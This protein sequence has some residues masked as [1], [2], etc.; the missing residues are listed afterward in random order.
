[1]EGETLKD[2]EEMEG[3]ESGYS[4]SEHILALA[5]QLPIC[6]LGWKKSLKSQ[7]F[8]SPTNP[9]WRLKLNAEDYRLKKY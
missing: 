6:S 9:Q 5:E 4:E 1:L 2:P 8:L 7:T 3:R